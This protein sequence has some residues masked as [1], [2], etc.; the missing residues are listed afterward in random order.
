MSGSGTTGRAGQGRGAS[1]RSG[2]GAGRWAAPLAL[3]LAL[4]ACTSA[5]DA[6]DPPTQLT[7]GPSSSASGAPPA[8]ASSGGGAGSPSSSA[9]R[10]ATVK[11]PTGGPS[12]VESPPGDALI[13]DVVESGGDVT[14]NGQKL[15]A[16]VGQQVQ[17]QVLSDR[18][19]VIH[20]HTGEDGYELEVTAG[21]PTTGTF[22]LDS[23]GSFEVESHELDK[24]IVILN[25]R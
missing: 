21:V 1:T 2:P 6:G 20:A 10:S 17:L 14:P 4:A 11:L 5:P 3:C 15:D 19:D 12:T 9:S 7:D 8:S 22:T 13:I 25:A 16:R 18:D 24:V 23:A